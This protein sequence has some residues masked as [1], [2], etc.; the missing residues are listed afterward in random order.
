MD[1][2]QTRRRCGSDSPAKMGRRRKFKA[3]EKRKLVEE[4]TA[5]GQSIS[6]VAR[7]YGLS[8][9]LLFRWRKLAEDGSMS[10]WT[11]T[12]RSCPSRR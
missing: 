2:G 8:P 6:S 4:A 1:L 7:R 11:P 12:R 5:P 3:D 10:T 9:S